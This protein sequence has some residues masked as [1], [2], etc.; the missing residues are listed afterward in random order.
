MKIYTNLQAAVG[1]VS[2]QR[3]RMGAQQSRLLPAIAV[4]E[5]NVESLSAS[6]SRIEDADYAVETSAL[7]RNL[8]IQQAATAMTSQ[9]HASSQL[10]LTLLSQSF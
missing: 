2:E 1:F 9:A 6:R 8:I 3:T 5:I 4:N 10:A 7:T